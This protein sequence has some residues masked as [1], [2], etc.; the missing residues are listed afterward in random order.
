MSDSDPAELPWS[1]ERLAGL[2]EALREQLDA[3]GVK[4]DDPVVRSTAAAVTRWIWVRASAL[5]SLDVV[6]ALGNAVPRLRPE[7]GVP[8]DSALRP[9]ASPRPAAE[10]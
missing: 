5:S 6:E 3:F 4:P 7:I 2:A 1:P 8:L 10:T 9:A